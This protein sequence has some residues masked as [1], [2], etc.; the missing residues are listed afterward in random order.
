MTEEEKDQEQ[1]E[2]IKS[3]P[4][5]DP[6][7]KIPLSQ[8]EKLGRVLI[9]VMCFGIVLIIYTILQPQDL[10]DIDGYKT[11]SSSSRNLQEV[12]DKAVKGNYSVTLTEAEINQMLQ[13]ELVAKQHGMLSSDASIK[14][15][16]V[17][18]KKDIAEVIIL[19]EVFGHEI[20]VSMYIQLRQSKDEKGIATDIHLH[21]GNIDNTSAM[22]KIGG[23]FGKLSIPQGFLRAV[24][25]DYVKIADT[26]AP[27]I[28]LGLRRMSKFEI[29]DK[30]VILDPSGSSEDDEGGDT[31][32]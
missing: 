5:S 4:K 20:T 12:L 18:L 6:R 29:Q 31:P 21:G 1:E 10:S 27:E 22:P 9:L 8:K 23:R 25:S 17:R 32:F 26:L 24:F 30:R 16:L 28:E 11:S 13:N 3:K 19:R 15:V 2:E 7:P 14:R